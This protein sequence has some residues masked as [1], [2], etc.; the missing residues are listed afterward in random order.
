MHYIV[1]RRTP[2]SDTTRLLY[3]I[4]RRNTQN[5][6]AIIIGFSFSRIIVQGRE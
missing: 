1:S 3:T 2:Y 6:D 5:G 4:G